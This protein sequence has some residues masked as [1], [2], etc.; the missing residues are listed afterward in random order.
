MMAWSEALFLLLGL[1]GFYLLVMYLENASIENLIG[2][3]ILTALTMLTRYA[4]VVFSIT[5]VLSIILFLHKPWRS[6]IIS[7]TLFGLLSVVPLGL[8]LIRNRLV[9]GTTTNRELLFHPIG[10]AHFSEAITTLASWILIP[11]TARIWVKVLPFIIIGILLLIAM[12]SIIKSEANI[13][14][15]VKVLS[16]FILLYFLFLTFSISFFDANT[17]LDG[18]ILSPVYVSGL[19]LIIAILGN[20][21]MKYYGY[22]L[23]KGLVLGL[24]ALLAVAYLPRDKDQVVTAYQSGLGFNS[25]YWHR[26]ETLSLLDSLPQGI[27]IF[28]NA[29]EAIYIH[30]NR[31]ASRLPS[32]YQSANQRANPE[33]NSRLA[34]VEAILEA[35]QGVIVYFNTIQID[36]IPKADELVQQMDLYPI[37]QASDGVIFG[38]QSSN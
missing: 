18:R 27:P 33:Y 9:A 3:A 32:R 14:I 13:P 30:S 36:S 11:D 31:P 17:P 38:V 2:A 1:L 23:A 22:G 21:S 6:R 4:G 8:W 26:S 5:G 12:W 35:K 20:V 10:K 28:S 7:A 19:I 16:I 15:F 37:Y 24:M 25:V 29:P 34:E